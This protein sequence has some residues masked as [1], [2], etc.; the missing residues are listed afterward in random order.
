MSQQ[1]YSMYKGFDIRF[2]H[3]VLYLDGSDGHISFRA[4]NLF[5]ENNVVVVALP[6]YTR[7]RTH[8]ITSSFRHINVMYEGNSTIGLSKLKVQLRMMCFISVK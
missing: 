6:A 4:L 3:I 2:C 5:K 1:L 7:H 8:V